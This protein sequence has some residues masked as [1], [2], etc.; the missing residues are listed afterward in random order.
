MQEIWKDIEGYEGI[1]QVS[2]FGGVKSLERKRMGGDATL[3]ERRLKPT[4]NGDKYPCVKL[5]KDGVKTTFKVH[6]LVAG[7]FVAGRKNNLQVNHIDCDKTNNH[8][9]NLEWVTQSENITHAF[10]N[11]LNPSKKYDLNKERL[12]QLLKDNRGSTQKIARIVG[13]SERL[14]RYYY[15]KYLINRR[16]YEQ[17]YY[18]R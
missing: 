17:G 8:H 3:K 2:N 10:G 16:K 5:Y 6:V 15:K 18:F 11:G 1:Y 12:I 13:C 4:L 7:C 9:S 14:L